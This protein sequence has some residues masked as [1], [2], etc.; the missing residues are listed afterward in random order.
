MDKQVTDIKKKEAEAITEKTETFTVKTRKIKW[1]HRVGILP[2]ERKFE[3][4]HITAGN[5]V[6]ISSLMAD[7]DI[8]LERVSYKDGIANMA[9]HTP[10][11]IR[12]IAT[13]VYNGK[14][15]PPASLI[16]YLTW[17]MD[18]AEMSAAILKVFK[19]L[20]VLGFTIT[21]ALMKKASLLNQE[22]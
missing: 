16:N 7:V 4:R 13:A 2:V 19:M 10:K 8:D 6:R 12:A 15:E 14:D 3:L 18:V 5:L 17:H 9:M 21:I 11:I 20:D 22:S 1:A